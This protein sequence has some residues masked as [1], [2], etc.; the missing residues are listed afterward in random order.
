MLDNNEIYSLQK[1]REDVNSTDCL[2]RVCKHSVK[3]FVFHK[4][5]CSLGAW[6]F[7]EVDPVLWTLLKILSLYLEAIPSGAHIGGYGKW[8]SRGT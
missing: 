5:P 2:R 8:R 3:T 4:R 7:I 1:A 6:Q